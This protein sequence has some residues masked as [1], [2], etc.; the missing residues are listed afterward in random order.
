MLHFE[1]EVDNPVFINEMLK[2]FHQV[3]IGLNDEDGYPYVV[4]LNY[5]YEMDEENLYVYVH[6]SKRGHKLD[7]MKKDP[8][9]CL[10][11]NAFRD[12][13]DRSWKKHVHDYRSVIA[14][15]TI[16]IID[17]KEDYDTFKKGYDLLYTC[18]NREIKPLEDRPSIPPMYIGKITCPMSKVTAKSE[19][20]IRTIED[21]PF[22]NVYEMPDDETP[23]DLS[24]IIA[25]KKNSKK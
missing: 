4:P 13:P 15:G 2:M 1:R 22:L 25:K 18:N 10:A 17:G 20:P 9:V 5:G 11:F 14:K 12:F 3:N 23:F 21:V 8:R 24:D 7:L 19:F 16:E 6:F